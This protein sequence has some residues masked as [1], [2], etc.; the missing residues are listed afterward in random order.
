MIAASLLIITC[1]HEIPL[2]GTGGTGSENPPPPPVTGLSCSADT[3]YFAGTILPLIR[4]SC[5]ISGCHDAVSSREGLTLDNYNG[6]INLVRAGNANESKLYKV[7]TSTNREDIMPPPP[8]TPLSSDA[9]AS[10]QKWINQ[11][12]KNNQCMADC[13]TTAFTYSGTV[14]PLINTYCKGCHNPSSLGGSVD[15]STYNGT[16]TVALNGK[17]MGS[18]KHSSGFVAMPQGGD[19]LPDCQIRQIEKWIEAGTANN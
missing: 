4:S 18:I 16:K 10:I 17:L 2:K 6:I 11:G 1:K 12:A 3:V 7:I 19:K 9:I 15:L 13:D 14:A 8:H 5:A